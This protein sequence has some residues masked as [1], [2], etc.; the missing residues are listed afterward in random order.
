[1]LE[2]SVLFKVYRL[3]FRRLRRSEHAFK[4][5]KILHLNYVLLTLKVHSQV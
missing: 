4:K 2:S 1:M 5:S 3:R